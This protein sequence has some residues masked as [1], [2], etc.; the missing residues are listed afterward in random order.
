MG[1]RVWQPG[2]TI[3]VARLV[4]GWCSG[5]S[6]SPRIRAA[7]PSAPRHRWGPSRTPF[8]N[9][10]YRITPLAPTVWSVVRGHLRMSL[11]CRNF[12]L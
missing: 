7:A 3:Y 10:P 11:V 6:W 2:G 5:W 8:S 4:T 12:A 1:E 9:T